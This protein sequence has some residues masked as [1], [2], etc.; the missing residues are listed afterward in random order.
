MFSEIVG[1]ESAMGVFLWGVNS[2]INDMTGGFPVVR[3]IG[4]SVNATTAT[5]SLAVS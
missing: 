2:E 5:E 1:D 4:G 3:E